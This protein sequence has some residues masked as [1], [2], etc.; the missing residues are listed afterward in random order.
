MKN[1]AVWMIFAGLALALPGCKPMSVTIKGDDCKMNGSF[2]KTKDGFP[3]NWSY[4]SPETVPNGDFDI[5]LDSSTVKEGKA[6]L[7]FQVRQCESIGGRLSPGFFKSFTVKPGET[8]IV[9]FW[10]MNSGC[11]FRVYVETGMKGNAGIYENVVQ[12]RESFPTWRYF[13]HAVKIPLNNDNLRFEANILSPGTI[14]FDDIRIEGVEDNSE[15]T[16]YPFRGDEE[17]K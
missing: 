7:R 8:Y 2:E 9:S 5:R 14:W 13:E 11:T 17:C 1:Y 12:T 6:S 3:V 10:V 16:V 15:R 4:Y